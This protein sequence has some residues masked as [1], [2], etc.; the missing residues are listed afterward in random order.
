MASSFYV[1][2]PSN[3]SPEVYPDNT[4]TH[5]RV[6]LPQP[7]TLEGQWEVGLAEI[8][9]PHQWY[10]LDEESTYSYTGNGEQW[11]TKRIPPGYYRNEAGLL[12]VLETNLGPMVRYS[13]DD[14]S[15]KVTIQLREGVEVMYKGALAEIL[16]FKGDTHIRSSLTVDNPMDIKHLHN[17]FVYCDIVEPHAVGHA[18]V[19]LIRVVTV[20]GRNPRHYE[21]YYLHQ[22]G[23]GLP[24][25]RGGRGQRGHGIG[26]I[27]GGLF[28]SAVP[29]LKKGAKALGKEALRT[30]MAVAGDVLD[31]RSLK[32]S[33]K[34][35]GLAASKRVA[36]KAVSS[37]TASSKSN[38]KENSCECTKSE[39][40]LFVIPPTQ[41]STEKGQWIEY[42][43]IANI[44]DSGPIEFYVSGSSEEYIDLSQTQLYVRAKITLPNGDDLPAGSKVGPVNLFLQS[45]FSQVDVSL[46]ERLI[47][48][49]TPTYP[50]RAM[51]ET[52]LS[53]GSDAKQTQLTSS[54]FYKDTAG[55]M[56]N[57]DPLA[58]DDAV[59]QGL[60]TRAAFTRRSKTVDMLGPIHS[61]IF[62]QDKYLLNGVSMKLKLIR[63]KD[64]FCLMSADADVE[65]K[66]VIQDA[67][68]FV[69]KIKLNPA[70]PL[71]HVRALEKAT[72]KYP[73][74]R[75]VT[76]MFS[77]LVGNMSFVQDHIFLGQLPK[78]L[79]VSCVTNTVN[80]S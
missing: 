40:D 2:L 13:W 47:S 8:V 60:K 9:Y 78:R 21:D 42:H 70:V 74:R 73:I 80:T 25:F 26:N 41:T 35:R 38:K 18:K 71:A 75:V 29:L 39:L 12:N 37:V 51:I 31:G 56:D 28:R 66:V 54:L 77:I 52:L 49:S 16:G 76:K 53:Y 24:V 3:S 6:K 30:G 32:S 59:N 64:Q 45:L 33:V 50:Y 58:A 4:L 44:T 22:I 17:L 19:P 57:P 63:S 67:S 62:F 15:G 7:I 68:L 65:Y 69:R 43:P 27:L 79:I 34:S 46:N 1:T 23:H 20:K 14:K 36:R 55:S 11:W 5:F 10:N 61:D 72:A 48:P